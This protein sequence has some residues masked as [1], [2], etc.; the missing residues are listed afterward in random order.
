MKNLLPISLALFTLSSFAYS[1]NVKPV[2]RMVPIE[3]AVAV[4]NA[5]VQLLLK[6]YAEIVSF[7]QDQINDDSLQFLAVKTAEIEAQ[8][9]A[10]LADSQESSLQLIAQRFNIRFSR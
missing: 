2:E 8:L 7:Y 1:G 6:S 5:R 4:D 3:S 9:D 10:Q